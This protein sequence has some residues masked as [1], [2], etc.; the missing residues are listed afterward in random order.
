MLQSGL[1]VL[2][3]FF[4]AQQISAQS[5]IDK[6]D[7]SVFPKAQKGMVQYVIEVPHSSID[8]D[9]NKKIEIYVGQYKDTDKC[10][11]QFL[12]GELV[13]K[14]LKG[15]GYQYYEFKTNGEIASTLMGCGDTGTIN[16]FVTAQPQLTDYNGRMP[17]V[18]YAPEGYDVQFKIYKAEP[19]TYRAYQVRS[20]K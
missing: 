9:A 19:E 15:Y 8:Q 13:Q 12:N 3:L 2:G 16:K 11:H 14:D 5:V 10:N 7:T 17:I 1:V 6:I 20:K 4:G 18:V